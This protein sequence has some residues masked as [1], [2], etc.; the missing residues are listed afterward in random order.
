MS[1]YQQ[2]GLLHDQHKRLHQPMLVQATRLST[3]YNLSSINQPKNQSDYYTQNNA[4]SANLVLYIWDNRKL[5]HGQTLQIRKYNPL[6]YKDLDQFYSVIW[7][8]L[9]SK[10][11]IDNKKQYGIP[12]HETNLNS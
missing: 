9:I 10:Q 5:L 2:H 12:H 1:S 11:I 4:G 7:L 3:K 8:D 6:I